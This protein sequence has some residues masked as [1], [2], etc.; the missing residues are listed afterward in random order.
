MSRRANAL[1]E[2]KKKRESQL[3]SLFQAIEG[4]AFKAIRA[5]T[6]MILLCEEQKANNAYNND[7]LFP[8]LHQ[9]I[10][11]IL[12]L[13]HYPVVYL[14]NFILIKGSMAYLGGYLFAMFVP[15][16]LLLLEVGV[17]SILTTAQPNSNER[18]LLTLV[19]RLLILVTPGLVLA[20]FLSKLDSWN[21]FDL[22]AEL[23]ALTFLM[24]I[25]ITTDL[26]VVLGFAT[27]QQAFA[28][29][30]TQIQHI[31]TTRRCKHLEH[32]AH[33]YTLETGQNYRL[34]HQRLKEFNKD[35]SEVG[36]HPHSFSDT[37]YQVINVPRDTM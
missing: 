1:R 15:A 7:S 5:R 22:G 6:K 12:V 34:Y 25:A 3:E 10:I 20:T 16:L 9:K 21:L 29:L 33:Q 4:A 28:F 35:F 36:I 23:I 27:H 24:L 17:C 26:L 2:E 32:I 11:Y 14:L 37:T 30:F 8:S 19:S 31:Q 13:P 18:K